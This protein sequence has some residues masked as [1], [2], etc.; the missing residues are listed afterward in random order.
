MARAI[1]PEV[2][3]YS[4][5]LAQR[6]PIHAFPICESESSGRTFHDDCL[7]GLRETVEYLNLVREFSL[8]GGKTGGLVALA[9]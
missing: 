5:A 4:P 3:T 8:T 6:E 2:S 7:A 9:S 1:Q